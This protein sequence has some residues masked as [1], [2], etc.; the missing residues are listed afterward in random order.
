MAQNLTVVGFDADDTLW[1]NERFFQLTQDRF[2]TLLADH[3][4]PDHLA[5]RLLAAERRN[6]GHYGFGIK[7]FVL[8]MIETALE[9]TDKRVPGEVIAELIAAGQEMLAHPIELLPHARDVVTRVADSHR[10]VL[11]TKGDL[12]DQERKL[13][14]SGLGDLFH[15]V[16]IVSDKT[17]ATYARIF[18]NHG[19]GAGR[20][21]MVGNSMKSDVVPMIEA[22]G[23]GVYVP[24]D[25]I[26]A[27]E[28]AEAPEDHPKYHQIN[29][30]SGLPAILD[31][32]G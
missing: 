22:G 28:R 29:D 10:V 3:A 12:L 7:G 18:A 17:P 21:M 23:W 15:G 16:E 25:L 26:W 1:H 30:L 11:I 6:I 13:A 5:E 8:S 32:L 20:G 2:A 27:L 14:Q 9:V 19:D 31:R 24:T 4:E